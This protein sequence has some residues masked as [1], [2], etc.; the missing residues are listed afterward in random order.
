MKFLILGFIVFYQKFISRFLGKNCRFY[1]PCSS[2]MHQAITNNGTI[3]GRFL[4]LKRLLRCHPFSKGGWDPVP[5]KN[6]N[7]KGD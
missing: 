2:Y 4:G 7:S 1:P 6:K 5:P 3:I